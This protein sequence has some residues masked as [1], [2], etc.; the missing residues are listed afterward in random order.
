LF[1]GINKNMAAEEQD[2]AAQRARM[3]ENQLRQRGIHDPAV[4]AAMS[5]VPR[6]HFVPDAYKRYAYK[7]APLP[8]PARQTISQPY[9]VAL[10]ISVL[11]LTAHE[12]VLEIGTGSG[13]AAAVLSR[14]VEEVHSV[15]RHERL[16]HYARRRLLEMGY[17]N[18]WVHH[19]DGTLGWPMRAPYDGIVVAAGGP[20]IPLPLRQQLAVGGRLVIPVGRNRRKQRLIRVT[21]WDQDRYSE[22]DLGA[23]AFV[24][25]IGAEGWK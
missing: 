3:V 4:L 17:D 2:F 13:Y 23:V 12:R 16:V 10:M 25:L 8:I 22:D 24:P 14:I 21:R 15:E 11:N 18:V 9:V 20:G 19:S 1:H 6:E 7:D 5:T